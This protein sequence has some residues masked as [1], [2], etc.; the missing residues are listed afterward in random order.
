MHEKWR[1]KLIT[2]RELTWGHISSLH[3]SEITGSC[4]I[5]HAFCEC[6][7]CQ[8]ILEFDWE[9][10]WLVIRF[11]LSFWSFC[12]LCWNVNC[13]AGL[14][15]N[16]WTGLESEEDPARW[17]Q[18]DLKRGFRTCYTKYDPCMPLLF[19]GCLQCL[20]EFNLNFWD[21]FWK[22]QIELRTLNQTI[23]GELVSV[24]KIIFGLFLRGQ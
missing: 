23:T 24:G 11:F 4:D 12:A 10:E 20:G 7:E 21:F 5:N 15:L 13:V 22:S 14:G 17:K 18:C 2:K 3:S 9:S 1:M 6:Y 16:C 19:S 8:N